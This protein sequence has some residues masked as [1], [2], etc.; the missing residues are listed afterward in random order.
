MIDV[1]LSRSDRYLAVSGSPSFLTEELAVEKAREAL[2]HDGLTPDDWH[3]RRAS[4]ANPP[5]QVMDRFGDKSGLL[6]FTNTVQQTRIVLVKLEGQR[7]F[8]RTS[9]AK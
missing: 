5:D 1:V 9:K 7:V 8:C 2:A 6:F 4:N 3:P